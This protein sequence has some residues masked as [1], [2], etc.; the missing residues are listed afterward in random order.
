MVSALV[1]TATLAACGGDSETMEVSY[2]SDRVRTTVRIE[3]LTV[4]VGSEGTAAVQ[5]R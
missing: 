4:F 2:K 1:L 5:L 3:H